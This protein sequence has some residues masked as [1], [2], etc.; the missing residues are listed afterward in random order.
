MKKKVFVVADYFIAKNKKDNKGLTNKK[1]Q[2]LLY[3]SQAFNLVFNK[4]KLFEDDIQAWIY[5]PVVPSVWAKFNEFGF[6]DIDVKID[7]KE[8]EQLTPA[9]KQLL[10]DIWDIYGKYDAKYLEALTHSEEPWIE[11]RREAEPYESS[12]NVISV[13]TMTDY[14]GRQIKEK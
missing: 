7:E 14:Y 11:A 5:G 2:K 8:F 9:E 13:G 4:R 3:Y 12:S 10:D 6:N 1:L